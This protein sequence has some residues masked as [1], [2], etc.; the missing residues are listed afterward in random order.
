MVIETT[1]CR[2]VFLTGTLDPTDAA[3][4]RATDPL[5]RQQTVDVILA[6]LVAEDDGAKTKVQKLLAERDESLSD[7][8]ATIQGSSF[9]LGPQ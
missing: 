5:T 2:P 3:Y 6:W 4:T 1:R 7:L 9:W 8:K